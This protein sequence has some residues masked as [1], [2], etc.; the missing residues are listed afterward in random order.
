MKIP[1]SREKTVFVV[2]ISDP[3]QNGPRTIGPGMTARKVFRQAI[4]STKLFRMLESSLASIS[5]FSPQ[6]EH[7]ICTLTGENFFLGPVPDMG[8]Y[9]GRGDWYIRRERK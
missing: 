1:E 4:H 3:N 8:T 2:A 7:T 5:I 9:N 6:C